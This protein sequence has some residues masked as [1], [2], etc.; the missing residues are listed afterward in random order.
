MKKT[1]FSLLI[2]YPLF[3]FSQETTNSFTHDGITR[4]YITY[5]PGVYD[6]SSAVPLVIA[7]H[8]LGDDMHSFTAIR[9]DLIADTANFIVVTPQAIV[10]TLLTN[11]TAWNSGVQTFGLTLNS[12]IDDVGFLSELIDT[13][14]ANYNIDEQQIYFCGFSMGG[15]MAQ[16][17]A[18]ELSDKVT[19]IASVAGTLGSGI[20][21][22]PGRSV[23]VCHFHG[24]KDGVVAYSGNQYGNDVEELI[25]FWVT[26]NNC[27]S[28]PVITLLPDLANDGYLITHSLYAGAEGGADVELYRVD[29]ADHE[30][31]AP[32]PT[33]DIFYTDEIWKFFLKQKVAVAE[34]VDIEKDSIVR[35]FPN[36]SNGLIKLYNYNS[37][38]TVYVYDDFGNLVFETK[39]FENHKNL[40]LKHLS[41][42]SYFVKIKDSEGVFME[43]LQIVH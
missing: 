39:V 10:E 31:L 24:T 38:A 16:R 17:L 12:T 19:A 2:L 27:E 1:L 21:C 42:G 40:N 22:S 34:S 6:G 30:W 3:L 11:L 7:L 8:G 25:N 14:S 18:C 13:I 35:V 41:A 15:F 9:M 37:V 43:K 4:D 32:P 28:S 26:N 36:P 33:N 5:A 23:P 20:N 29:S